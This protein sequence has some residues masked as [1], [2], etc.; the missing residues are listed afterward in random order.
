MRYYGRITIYGEYLL[1]KNLAQCLV[2]KSK[3]FLE[4]NQLQ[5]I[6]YSNKYC[7]KKDGVLKHLK[8]N[9]LNYSNNIFGNLVLGYGFASSTILCFLHLKNNSSKNLIKSIDKQIN[10]FTPSDLDFTSIIKQENGLFDNNS[11]TNIN[12]SDFYYSVIIIPKER[13]K[14]L[15][16][17]QQ[18]IKVTEFLQ[19]D[20][21]S[22][23]TK[24]LLQTDKL[25][26]ELFL[27]YC[28]I[29]FECKVYSLLAMEITSYLLSLDIATKCIGGL[30]DKAIL[31]VYKTSKQKE[32]TENIL[33][34]KW[35]KIQIAE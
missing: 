11:W 19:A 8:E 1:H 34:K 18:K 33:L 9:N 6:D 30:Y 4:S 13:K 20:I 2:L 12:L 16:E 28:K 35:T 27:E 22:K 21:S 26:Y 25:N 10:H 7:I 32:Q 31:I 17:I 3:M 15:S 24:E 14:S 23:L 5:N 29:L